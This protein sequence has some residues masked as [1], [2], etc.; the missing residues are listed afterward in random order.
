MPSEESEILKCYGPE[1]E[2]W[3]IKEETDRARVRC[4]LR[5]CTE[6]PCPSPN[7]EP[8]PGH[9]FLGLV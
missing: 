8:D 7:S 2:G 6:V 5:T 3:E 4:A 1:K 9:G